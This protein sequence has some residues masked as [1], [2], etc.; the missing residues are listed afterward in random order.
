MFCQVFGNEGGGNAGLAKTAGHVQSGRHNGRLDRVE[1]IEAFGEI[2]KAMPVVVGLEHPV[3]LLA[4][5]VC[6]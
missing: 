4:H 3:G 5:T 1:H 2:A 6:G